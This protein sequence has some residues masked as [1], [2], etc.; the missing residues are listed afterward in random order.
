MW[1]FDQW[2]GKSESKPEYEMVYVDE[3][4][5]GSLTFKTVEI[6]W[7]SDRPPE[8]ITGYVQTDDEGIHFQSVVPFVMSYGVMFGPSLNYEFTTERFVPYTN[9][10]DWEVVGTEERTFSKK[11]KVKRRR[12][13]ND[14]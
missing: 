3:T 10:E 14:D 9:I 13:V 7:A 11:E 6:R 1:P 12:K 2:L 5:D 8:Q 4:F